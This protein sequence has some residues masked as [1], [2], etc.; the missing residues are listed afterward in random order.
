MSANYRRIASL[1]FLLLL[2]AS[3]Y[4][5]A[6]CTREVTTKTATQVYDSVPTFY[7]ASG[8]KL[9]NL[10]ETVPANTRVAICEE[11]TV[12]LFAGKKLWYKISFGNARSGWIS[13]DQLLAGAPVQDHGL[14]IEF[15][16][17]A[18]ADDT[19]DS[20]T[21]TT[22]TPGIPDYGH[23]LLIVAALFFVLLGIVGKVVF[24]AVDNSS[25]PSLRACVQLKKFVKALIAAPLAFMA[26]LNLADF[27]F[28]SEVAVAVFFCMAFQNGF[29]W[30]TLVPTQSH[31]Q[32]LPAQHAVGH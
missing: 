29:F 13:A 23:T 14:R 30:Q 32:K 4:L 24:D 27:A 11:A 12:G 17:S 18:Y 5:Q 15:I 1:L 19:T 21:G 2:S 20:T 16:S 10:V 28:T 3:G 9:G 31:P 25:E 6:Q 26:F 7:S 22:S 8:W